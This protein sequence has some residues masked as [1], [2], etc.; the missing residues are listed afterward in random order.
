MYTQYILNT[1][2]IHAYLHLCACAKPNT[3]LHQGRHPSQNFQ[4]NLKNL[5][6]GQDLSLTEHSVA[7]AEVHFVELQ[8]LK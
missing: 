5:K 2:T 7:T 8:C 4:K 1:Y 6:I 3:H